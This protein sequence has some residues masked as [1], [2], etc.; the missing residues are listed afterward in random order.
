MQA[1]ALLGSTERRQEN[2]V[3]TFTELPEAPVS[4]ENDLTLQVDSC[5]CHLRQ[6]ER[7]SWRTHH[8]YSEYLD[9]GVL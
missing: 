1:C 7:Y 6:S 8:A 5:L 9:A 2:V 3:L 4:L